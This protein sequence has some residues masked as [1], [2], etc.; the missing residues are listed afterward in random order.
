MCLNEAPGHH[1]DLDRNETRF[2]VFL[3]SLKR[4]DR[5]G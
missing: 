5:V 1:G 4:M 3:S 2:P